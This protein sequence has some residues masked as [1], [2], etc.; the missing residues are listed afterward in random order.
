M[1]LTKFLG[2]GKFMNESR[3]IF[4]LIKEAEMRKVFFY[5]IIMACMMVFGCATQKMGQ[6][7]EEK[8]VFDPNGYTT[9]TITVNGKR[10]NYRA[11]ENIS[12]V[13]N[14]VKTNHT[15]WQE[16]NIYV[17]ESAYN[18]STVPILFKNAV[19]GYMP[20]DP[21]RIDGVSRDG[22]AGIMQIALSKGYVVVSPGARGR[23]SQEVYVPGNNPFSPP[24]NAGGLYIG[25]APAAI[26]DLK[27]AVRYLRYNDAVMPGS[28]EKIISD[29]TSA[30]GALSALLGASGNNPL[31]KPYL[32][33][34]GAAPARDDIFAVIAFCP[35]T[36]LDH[37]DMSYE[38]LYN[39]MNDI[40]KKGGLMPQR[41]QPMGGGNPWGSPDAG[42]PGNTDQNTLSGLNDAEKALSRE[43]AAFFPAY[44]DSLG[45]VTPGGTS[46]AADSA[47]NGVYINYIASF[48]IKSAQDAYNANTEKNAFRASF[49]W[50]Q[51]DNA[52]ANITGINFQEYLAYVMSRQSLKP[53]PAFDSMGVLDGIASGEND[54]FGT[55]TVAAQNFTEAGW[56]R[57]TANAGRL[58]SDIND[59]VFLMNAMNFIGVENIDTAPNWYIRHG[60][61]DRDTAF[62]VSVNLYTKL[63]NRGY[64]VDY[65]LAWEKPHSGDYD[66]DEVFAWIAK[67]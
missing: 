9:G 42:G 30:G 40:R 56:Q 51:F 67:L 61:I 59:R 21:E 15:A 49:P 25:K 43:L 7:M 58:P 13:A 3:Y 26:V 20:S 33:A 64:E 39:A 6:H 50:L 4:V 65:K 17:P 32:E 55:D 14:P 35:I 36:D 57:N 19:G 5:S 41:G 18:D 37:A 10:I 44:L 1:I 48:V 46:L 11:W 34:I 54:E 27:A 24:A 8:L 23:T 22:G 66:L 16:M 47:G 53:V 63:R 60:T 31:Y 62:T 45:L 29:G 28:A 2:Y 52:Y 12:Y 38:W